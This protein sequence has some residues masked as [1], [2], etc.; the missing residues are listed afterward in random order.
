MQ[1]SI[2]QVIQIPTLIMQ[3]T[4]KKVILEKSKTLTEEQENFI[5]DVFGILPHIKEESIP[6]V[7][8]RKAGFF[9]QPLPTLAMFPAKGRVIFYEAKNG[10][11][12]NVDE[13][14]AVIK[15]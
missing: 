14:I 4:Q 15:L 1:N 3:Q 2:Q 5:D 9:N 6:E 7:L 10:Q 13:P 11:I 12:T 8:K